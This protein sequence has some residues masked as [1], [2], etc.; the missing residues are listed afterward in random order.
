[1]AD[2]RPNLNVEH[3]LKRPCVDPDCGCR[4]VSTPRGRAT[5]LDEAAKLTSADRQ[6]VY[7]HPRNHFGCTAALVTGYLQR[8]GLLVKGASLDGHDWAC[9]MMLDKVSRY[10]GT[11]GRDSLVDVAGYARTAEMLDEPNL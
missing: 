10:A 2:G 7:G 9:L 3:G 8:R 5:I 4:A 1:M 11:R 6:A